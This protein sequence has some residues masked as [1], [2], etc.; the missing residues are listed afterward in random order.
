MAA[1][2]RQQPVSELMSGPV[3]IAEP[4]GSPERPDNSQARAK[5]GPSSADFG[6]G[7]LRRAKLGPSL[8]QPGPSSGQLEARASSGQLEARASSGQARAKPEDGPSSGQARAK[9]IAHWQTQTSCHCIS[10]SASNPERLGRPCVFEAARVRVAA[11]PTPRIRP[12]ESSIAALAASYR[13]PCPSCGLRLL[14]ITVTAEARSD[15]YQCCSIWL[16]TS[17][18]VRPSQP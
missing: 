17:L 7:G 5:P 14:Q 13:C 18:F 2:R 4:L 6:L 1:P 15:G 9:E 10:S 16:R 8:G 3:D 11:A 12:P